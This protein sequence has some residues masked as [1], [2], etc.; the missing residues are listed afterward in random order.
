MNGRS[1]WFRKFPTRYFRSV[2]GTVT[3]A[4]GFESSELLFEKILH[5][6]R[7][8]TQGN[9]SVLTG[10]HFADE[11]QGSID[12]LHIDFPD[13]KH[14]HGFPCV[15][16][17]SRFDVPAD[18]FNRRHYFVHAQLIERFVEQ[19][20]DVILDLVLGNSGSRKHADERVVRFKYPLVTG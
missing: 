16:V 9:G 18:S 6:R 4:A 14:R 17:F 15:P 2:D 10:R 20:A 13:Q 3:T 12:S 1:E 19:G 7:S 8:G 5:G 11:S